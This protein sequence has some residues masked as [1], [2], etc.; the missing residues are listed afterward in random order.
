MSDFGGL[1]GIIR[2]AQAIAQ[3]PAPEVACPRC[4]TPLQFNKAGV[5]NC[6]MGDYR[7]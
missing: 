5:S 4:G 2:E 7:K 1:G 6:P 3:N